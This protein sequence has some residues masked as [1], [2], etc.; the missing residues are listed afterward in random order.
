MNNHA[1]LDAPIPAERISSINA[2][3]AQAEPP[4]RIGKFLIHFDIIRQDWRNLLPMM[5]SCVVVEAQAHYIPGAIEYTAFC[6]AFD[7]V[8]VGL[9][10]PTYKVLFTRQEDES[11]TF[12]FEREKN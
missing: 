7:E 11:V 5:A 8:E 3:Y 4:R 10:P 2:H 1:E 12:A 6:D 9:V